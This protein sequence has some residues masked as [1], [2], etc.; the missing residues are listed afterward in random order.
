MSLLISSNQ[1]ATWAFSELVWKLFNFP[2]CYDKCWHI[3]S[4][5]QEL[6]NSV[7]RD[8]FPST[9]LRLLKSVS[10]IDVL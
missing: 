8:A 6:D 3:A 4:E 10:F 2:R 7:V 5:M 1:T 9:S